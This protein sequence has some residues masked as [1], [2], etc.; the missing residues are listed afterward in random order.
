MVESLAILTP[1]LA[2]GDALPR[3]WPGEKEA[4]AARARS[5]VHVRRLRRKLGPS[6]IET[7]IGVGYRFGGPPL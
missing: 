1:E 4:P 7:V 5:T 6:Y 2:R 3:I